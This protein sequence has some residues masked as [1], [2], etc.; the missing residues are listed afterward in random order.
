MD[1]Q[2]TTCPDCF[3]PPNFTV[4]QLK[5]KDDCVYYSIKCRDCGDCWDEPG[6]FF[7]ENFFENTDVDDE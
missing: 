2:P 6:E 7:S 3:Y 4:L 5:D 1:F